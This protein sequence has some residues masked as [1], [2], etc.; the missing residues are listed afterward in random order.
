MTEYA[1]DVKLWG[2]CRVTADKVKQ[3]RQKMLAALGSMDLTFSHD[4]VTLTQ[5]CI[6]DDSGSCSELFE[7]DGQPPSPRR[8]PAGDK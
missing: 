6:E 2:T 5:V 4:G 8:R 3:A 1:F 7:V